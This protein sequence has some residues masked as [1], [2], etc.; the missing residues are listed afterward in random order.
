MTEIVTKVTQLT[1]VTLVQT[2]AVT[3]L[4]WVKTK[5]L[6]ATMEVLIVNVTLKLKLKSVTKV[7]DFPIFTQKMKRC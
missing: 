4:H 1:S 2:E 5:A 7:T 6:K 3:K